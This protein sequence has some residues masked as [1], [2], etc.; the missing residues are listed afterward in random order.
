MGLRDL[1]P[2]EENIP[3]RDKASQTLLAR[4]A[5]CPR[6]TYLHV[7][8][9]GG[10]GSHAMHRGSAMHAF[11]QRLIEMLVERGEAQMPWE[12]GKDLVGE[13]VGEHPEWVI[14]PD[15]MD[16]LR[17]AAF[18]ICECTVID[19]GSVL[20]IE[21]LFELELGGMRVRGKVDVAYAAGSTLVI[22][23]LKSQAFV[24]SQEEIDAKVQLPLYALLVG[25][26]H[27]VREEPCQECGATGWT[28][29]VRMQPCRACVAKG[30][31]EF[32]EAP[33]GARFNSFQL[34]EVYPRLEP[35]LEGTARVL[36]YRR[37]IIDRG[38]LVDHRIYVEGLVSGIRH[39]VE[40]G[41]WPAIPGSH[42]STCA[43]PSE[44]PLPARLRDH[45]GT[46]TTLTEAQE[47]AQKLVFDEADL[48][49]RRRELRE[50]AKAHGTAIAVGSDEV[51]DFQTVESEEWITGKKIGRPDTVAA[52]EAMQA[53]ID[54]AVRL[55]EPFDYWDFRRVRHS[56]KFAKR[57]VERPSVEP[58]APVVGAP[59]ESPEE[60][61]ARLDEQFG[62]EAPF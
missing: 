51:F 7:K 49:S 8:H 29:F 2:V 59:A 20:A 23:D 43:A 46:V 21:K 44:C 62:S 10:V 55:G 13:I 33:L 4:Q 25:E 45:H 48:A 6:S 1:P 53:A 12:V 28:D 11:H 50:F 38:E 31:R 60:R 47:A 37:R 24:P 32:P 26:G 36:P 56:S 57:K 17:I 39:G 18:H 3:P 5:V 58:V 35:W 14:P 42:C 27:P 52:R 15:E 61:Q 34:D 9:D 40:S 22:H 54:R 30:R 41:E 16:V 19:P